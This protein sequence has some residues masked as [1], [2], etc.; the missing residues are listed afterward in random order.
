MD[1]ISMRLSYH[2]LA[3]ES[4]R[5]GALLVTIDH[6]RAGVGRGICIVRRALGHDPKTVATLNPRVRG[7]SARYRRKLGRVVPVS[8]SI[9]KVGRGTELARDQRDEAGGPCGS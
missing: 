4:G 3:L 6:Q 7:S 1:S 5:A 9:T 2:G 8:R